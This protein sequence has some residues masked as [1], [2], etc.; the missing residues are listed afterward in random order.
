MAFL[1]EVQE[2][3]KLIYGDKN[4]NGGYLKWEEILLTADMS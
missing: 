3:K 1:Y 2:Q 4:Q